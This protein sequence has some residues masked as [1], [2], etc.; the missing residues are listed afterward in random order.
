ME[1]RSI[2][3]CDKNE[4]KITKDFLAEFVKGNEER[5][6]DNFLQI[7]KHLD[8]MCDS[9]KSNLLN[10]DGSP[11]KNPIEISVISVLGQIE[12]AEIVKKLHFYQNTFEIRVDSKYQ[13]QRILFF[14]HNTQVNSIVLTFGFTKIDGNPDTDITNSAAE[15]TEEIYRKVHSSNEESLLW[16]GDEQNE[17]RYEI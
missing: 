16:I 17:Y 10:K 12:R 11:T 5:V 7:L 13:H 3:Y 15:K 14:A 9:K 1:F 6:V 8:V 2:I 4:F